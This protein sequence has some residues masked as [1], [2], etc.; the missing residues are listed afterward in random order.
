VQVLLLILVAAVMLPSV[1]ESPLGDHVSIAIV[2]G[3]VGLIVL[4]G[5]T[6]AAI[7]RRGLDGPGG[8]RHLERAHRTM[9]W[10]QR[11][12]VLAVVV[13]AVGLGF[14]ES[15]R[16]LVGD[17]PL[18][19]EALT[20]APAIVGIASAWWIFHPFEQRSRESMLLRR[21]DQGLPVHPPPGRAAWVAMQVRSQLLILLAPFALLVLGAESMRLAIGGMDAAPAW[22][23]IAGS[24]G[25]FVLV[26][27]IAPAVVVR[28]VGARPLPPGEV[29]STLEEMCRAT[30]VRVRDLL[31]W[32]T[33]GLMVNAGVTGL[34]APLRWVMLT[35]GLL[36][37]LE[38]PQVL[39]VMAHELG[40]VR[41]HHM[42]WMGVSVL[43]LAIGIGMA[44]EPA[45]A[46]ARTW[47]WQLGGDLDAA[48]RDLDRIDLAAA[49]F[50]LFGVLLGFGWV[51]RRFE[52]QA[53]A[54]AAAS[55]SGFETGNDVDGG[56]PETAVTPL[57][58]E[59]MATA[60][61]AVAAANG[62]SVRRFTWRHGSIDSRRRHLRTLPGVDRNAMPIDR[63][64]RAIKI[65]SVLV[66]LAGVG[67]WW[68]TDDRTPAPIGSDVARVEASS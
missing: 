13:G 29:R 37:T 38:R 61:T 45:V 33:G 30:G 5:A 63:I 11:A 65:V 40:H 64:V 43:A 56:R 67:W 57:G 22:L 62:V 19:D 48:V 66:V 2:L 14:R 59:A 54:F 21:L 4:A 55:L 60:L 32:P 46:A 36:E 27:L 44:L 16:R 17:P 25:V 6:H 1:G 68:S 47:R 39:A 23:S 7:L 15:V 26:A 18:L 58:A 28:L 34:V 3:A 31:I 52:R 8:L 53:D 49:G 35:D 51:S 10:M 41:R 12:A 42:A 50:V 24:V 20:I 9:R